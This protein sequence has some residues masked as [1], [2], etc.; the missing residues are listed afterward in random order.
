MILYPVIFVRLTHP[1][2]PHPHRVLYGV[3]RLQPTPRCIDEDDANPNAQTKLSHLYSQSHSFRSFVCIF[4]VLCEAM[5]LLLV[6]V[7]IKCEGTREQNVH[8]YLNLPRCLA[9]LVRCFVTNMYMP[10]CD[11]WGSRAIWGTTLTPTS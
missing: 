9:S 7:H 1:R 5:C 11:G 3:D 4:L 10:C 6:L 2:Y 8:V